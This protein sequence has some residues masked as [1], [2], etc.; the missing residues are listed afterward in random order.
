MIPIQYPNPHKMMLGQR[1]KL[2]RKKVLTQAE[3]PDLLTQ[4]VIDAFLQ[5]HND[6]RA[7]DCPTSIGVGRDPKVTSLLTG[8]AT[9]CLSTAMGTMVEISTALPISQKRHVVI[10]LRLYGVTHKRVGCGI[11]HCKSPKTLWCVTMIHLNWMGET[12][13]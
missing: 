1:A 12:P 3:T 13:Y 2:S 11:T 10:I 5:F 9:V 7:N 6:A 4:E 8:V